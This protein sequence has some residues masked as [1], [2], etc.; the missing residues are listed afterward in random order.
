MSVENISFCF[1]PISSRNLRRLMAHISVCEVSIVIF[2]EQ[3][4]L[5]PSF[6]LCGIINISCQKHTAAALI[7]TLCWLWP[8]NHLGCQV[9]VALE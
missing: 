5:R 4:F 2:S 9:N 1:K 6:K 8:R 7:V 3:G